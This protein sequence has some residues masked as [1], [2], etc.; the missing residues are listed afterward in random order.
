MQETDIGFRNFLFQDSGIVF[1]FIA[2]LFHDVGS[3]A[4]R[5]GAIVTVLGNF[6][7]RP[8]YYKAGE[9][10]DIK[11]ILSVTTG[12][13]NIKCFIITQLYPD[14]KFQQRIPETLQLLNGNTAHKVDR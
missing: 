14:T 4:H 3:T 12:S 5:S 2:Q 10:G 6:L 8:C 13:Y 7:S 11:R 1:E 9:R